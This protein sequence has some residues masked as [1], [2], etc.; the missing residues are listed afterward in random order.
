M[1]LADDGAS[2]GRRLLEKSLS[3]PELNATDRL[4][5]L[6][7]LGDW[8]QWLKRSVTASNY[9]RQ[10]YQLSLASTDAEAANLFNIPKELP[11]SSVFFNKFSSKENKI[12]DVISVDLE[13]LK[14]GRV[15]N[16]EVKGLDLLGNRKSKRIIRKLKNTRFRPQFREGKVVDAVI[17]NRNYEVF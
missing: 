1:A 7:G 2:I 15:S 11:D 6:V 4:Y 13:I 8:F 3:S 17:K 16:I 9:Y 5:L 12:A 14:T 10:A